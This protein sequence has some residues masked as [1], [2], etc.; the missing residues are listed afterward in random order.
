MKLKSQRASHNSLAFSNALGWYLHRMRRMPIPE[1]SWRAY[2]GFM[3]FFDKR[4]NFRVPEITNL[5]APSIFLLSDH[6]D[7]ET[8]EHHFPDMVRHHLEIAAQTMQNRFMVFDIP[9]HFKDTINWHIDP[10]T[11]RTWPQAF[12]GDVNLR[13]RH[14]GGPK[15]VWEINRLYPLY[16]LCLAYRVTQ[17]PDFAG[18]ALN[19]IGSWIK[20]NPYP[21]GVNWTSGIEA[22]VRI[23]NLIWSLSLLK[24]YNFSPRELSSI[25]TFVW[26]HAHHLF[27]YRSRHSS[28]NNHLLAEAFGLFLAGLYFPALSGSKKWFHT[29]KEILEVEV[30][31]Q[32]LDDG[33]SFEYSTTYLGFVLDFY[34]L[35]MQCCRSQDIAYSSQVDRRI[36]TSCEFICTIMD[37]NGNIPNIGDQDSA[38]LVGF[39]LTN[40]ENFSSIL[41]T[42]A[43][44]F[45]RTDLSNGGV[46]FKTW[47]IT[48]NRK[49]LTKR[50]P[51]LPHESKPV[52]KLL[53][54]SGLAVI[55]DEIDGNEILFIGNGSSMGLPPLYAH[56]HLDALSFVLSIGGN[57]VF[58]DPGTYLYHNAESWR[59]YFRSTQAH[60]TIRINQKELSDQPGDFMFG[61]PY[62]IRWNRLRTE[63]HTVLWEASHSAYT[64][65]C[66]TIFWDRR[67]KGFTIIDIPGR[68]LPAHIELFFHIHPDFTISQEQGKMLIRNKTFALSLESDNALKSEIHFGETCPPLG[69]YSSDFN[70]LTPG[71]TIKSHGILYA[72]REVITRIG[73]EV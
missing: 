29:G 18:K 15:F 60:N 73:L 34:L 65:V 19:L 58:V 12:W 35:F 62:Y 41:N 37:Q 39:G 44:L 50:P 71:F 46:D 2:E 45:H 30:T 9:V 4:K 10:I 68:K 67:K 17:K 47:A 7:A 16:S 66:R 53:K 59:H 54:E 69:W 56:G 21:R 11:K 8:I 55:K 57:P 49:R 61:K 22:G 14:F 20:D 13:D 27:R 63:G 36:E 31:R 70:R 5:P 6:L 32:L 64:G 43:T 23:A 51:R 1:L 3:K 72:R 42:G 25:N 48:G 33:G 38:V 52:I 26:F 28:A 40:H 24:G